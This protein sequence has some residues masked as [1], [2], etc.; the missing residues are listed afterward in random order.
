[1]PRGTPVGPVLVLAG[2]RAGDA[3]GAPGERPPLREDRRAD[4][5]GPRA[6]ACRGRASDRQVLRPHGG[7]YPR[8]TGAAGAAARRDDARVG[9]LL[10]RA[11][12]PG[13]VSGGGTPADRRPR[14][15]RRH[16]PEVLQPATYGPALRIDRLPSREIKGGAVPPRLPRRLLPAG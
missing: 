14:P 16:R 9:R 12:V 7:P 10:L 13:G 3:P 15:R 2:A 6:S 8:P 1:Q 5:I 11:G 4:E